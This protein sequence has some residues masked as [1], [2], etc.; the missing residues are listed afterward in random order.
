MKKNLKIKYLSSILLILLFGITANTNFIYA[1]SNIGIQNNISTYINEKPIDFKEDKEKAKDWGKEKKKEFENKLT[2]NEKKSLENYSKDVQTINSKFMELNYLSHKQL[3]KEQLDTMKDLDKALEKANVTESVITYKPI[4]AEQIGFNGRL[5]WNGESMPAEQ[6]KFITQFKDKDI[7]LDS[8]LSTSLTTPSLSSDEDVLLKVTVPKGGKGSPYTKVKG[9]VWTNKKSEYELILDQSYQL[10]VTTIKQVVLKG[11]KCLQV[12]AD[13][14]EVKDF[15]NDP[16][17]KGERWGEDNYKDWASTLD[18]EKENALIDYL[19]FNGEEVNSYLRNNGIDNDKLDKQIEEMSEALEQHSIPENIIVYR[20]TGAEEFGLD[21]N[22]E[23]TIGALENVLL[24][25]EFEQKAYLSTSLSSEPKSFSGKK[26]I[27]RLLV[28][29]GATGAYISAMNNV[30]KTEKEILLDKGSR[31]K[32]QSIR[33][34][35][36]KGDYKYIINAILKV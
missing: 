25:Q 34:V 6:A 29:K 35:S 11:K 12:E 4:E 17:G 9:S 5:F 3:N 33:E 26:Y 8:Y 20:R 14:K 10:H 2:K 23:L 32:I 18:S 24:N 36:I 15:K 21:P 30:P 31:Y 22:K 16:N 7:P 27:L 1:D 13:L 28:P 19:G